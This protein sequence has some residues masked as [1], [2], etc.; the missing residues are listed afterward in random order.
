[1][2]LPP[3][4]GGANDTLAC[5]LPDAATGCAGAA[6]TVLGTTLADAGDGG[7]S[8]FPFVAVTVHVYDR[9][10]VKESTSNGEAA[11]DAKPPAPPFADAQFAV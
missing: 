6:G 5:A 1:M 9:P 7:P 2:V 8:P 10:F 11:P 4:K 3:S